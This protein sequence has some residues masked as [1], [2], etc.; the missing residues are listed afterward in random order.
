MPA[1]PSSMTLQDLQLR[2]DAWIKSIGKGYFSEL[3]N[4]VLL[5]EETGELARVIARV[6]GDQRPKPGDLTDPR[7]NLREEIADVLWVLTCI[8]NQTGISL[9]DA[10]EESLRK[11]TSRD[12]DRFS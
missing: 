11:K 6:Y 3:T 2:V 8:A 12:K 4:M 1:S 10:F 9:A 5:A 7:E